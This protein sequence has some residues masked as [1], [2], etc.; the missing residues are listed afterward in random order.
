MTLLAFV[1][2]FAAFLYVIVV[3]IVLYVTRNTEETSLERKIN[4]GSQSSQSS[5]KSCQCNSKANQDRV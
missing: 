4:S 5:K 3:C 2:L 1:F